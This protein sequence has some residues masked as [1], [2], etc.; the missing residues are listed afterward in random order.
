MN[1]KSKHLLFFKKTIAVNECLSF[2]FY[3][4]YAN[5]HVYKNVA[6]IFVA[7]FDTEMEN[8]I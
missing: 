3:S 8:Y 2:S 1:G 6:A 5:Y 7:L 4:E